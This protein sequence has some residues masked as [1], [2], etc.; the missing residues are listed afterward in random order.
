ML[1][2]F[3]SGCLQEFA[4]YFTRH[5]HQHEDTDNTETDYETDTTAAHMDTASDDT[6]PYTE[7]VWATHF[8]QLNKTDNIR[9]IDEDAQPAQAFWRIILG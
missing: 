9:D 3:H 1:T 7:I 8:V 5:V 6:D 2:N 4:D